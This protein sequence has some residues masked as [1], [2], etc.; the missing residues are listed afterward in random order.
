MFN[1]VHKWTIQRNIFGIFFSRNIRFQDL[2][3]LKHRDRADTI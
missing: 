2:S 1:D 3:M